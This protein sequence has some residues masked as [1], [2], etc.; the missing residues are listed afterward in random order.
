MS[1][2]SQLVLEWE[3]AA[4]RALI[5]SSKAHEM[6]LASPPKLTAQLKRTEGVLACHVVGPCPRCGHDNTQTKVLSAVTTSKVG[7]MDEA[8]IRSSADQPTTVTIPCKCGEPHSGRP[9]DKTGCGI[10]MN[11]H[12]YEEF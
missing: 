9:A 5:W 2:D 6:M 12:L 10:F 7:N 3:T 1:T 11:L 4:P 8:A